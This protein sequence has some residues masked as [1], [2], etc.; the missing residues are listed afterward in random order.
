M[1][2]TT[3]PLDPW[4]DYC[5]GA[6]R[7]EI[8][9]RAEAL[10][11]AILYSPARRETLVRVL[12]HALTE[13]EA[14]SGHRVEADDEAGMWR[15]W[16]RTLGELANARRDSDEAEI[17]LDP[18]DEAAIYDA[19]EHV[20]DDR[21]DLRGEVLDAQDEIRRAKK[22][23]PELDCNVDTD[24]LAECVAALGTLAEDLRAGVGIS[25][26]EKAREVLREF[27]E[28]T[29]LPYDPDTDSLAECIGF[30]G[31]DVESTLI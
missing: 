7:R 23:I 9:R 10:A 20:Y 27:Q 29:G 22:A 8:T 30:L 1:G 21:K 31:R 13:I 12:S 28:S 15:T 11:N 14:L 4:L 16:A 2:T 25:E 18:P 24:T 3:P 17:K 19:I 26:I 6:G 5:P